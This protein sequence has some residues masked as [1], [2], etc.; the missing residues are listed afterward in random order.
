MSGEYPPAVLAEL[1]A[2]VAC[3]VGRWGLAP[4]TE[5]SLLNVSENATFALG[6]PAG[7]TLVLRVQRLGYSSLQEIRSELAWV[8]A[9]RR[10]GI[11]ETASPVPGTDGDLVQRLEPQS[12][13]IP[14]AA[15]AAPPPV[16]GSLALP[17]TLAPRWAVAF[18]R[19]PGRAPDA[20]SASAWFERLGEVT[21][22]L[23]G[24]ARAWTPPAGFGRRR[25]DVEAMVGPD[26][27]WG[28]W[29][30]APGLDA[31][32]V[33]IVERALQRIR[34]RLAMIGTG[35]DVFGLVHADLRLA[36]LLVD[37]PRLRVIDF[38]DCGFA[39]YLYDFAGAVSFIEHEP[40]VA[41]LR[42]AWCAGYRKVA[43]L[44]VEQEAELA[45]FVVLRR[46]LLTAWLASHAETPFARQFG[47]AYTAGTVRL[48]QAFLRG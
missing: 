3:N 43:T 26:A 28:P 27:R 15:P 2:R 46:V 10:E 17:G 33:G 39:W 45:T 9:L 11:V 4:G 37:G 13:P 23:H 35:G 24:H 21:A 32:G 19:L 14:E 34:R 5:V 16:A 44:S 1:T 42:R 30:A 6:D 47:T 7:R 31:D 18:E 38:D 41:E 29:R 36:N 8:Q 22:R 12:E 25:W 48:A 40:V 20:R